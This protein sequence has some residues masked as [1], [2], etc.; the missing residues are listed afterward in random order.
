VRCKAGTFPAAG[1]KQYQSGQ[2]APDTIPTSSGAATP[3]IG[4]S[5]LGSL[6]LQAQATSTY[7]SGPQTCPT[8][9]Q[10][11]AMNTISPGKV[12]FIEGSP[13]CPISL[14][15]NS[16][17]SPIILVIAQGSFN[18]TGNATFYGLVYAAN[19]NNSQSS[20]VNLSGC[21]HIQGLVAVDG[22]G[23]VSVG[24]CKNNLVF[25]KSVLPSLQTYGGVTL[26]TNSFRALRGSAPAEP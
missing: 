19:T 1:C 5:Q 3:V 16:V 14:S 22:D 21:A 18:L 6:R 23:G 17:G 2:V 15:G 10:L 7:F 9:A 13:T 26:A 8:S 12:V 25:D 20:L 4:S 11:P 24:S